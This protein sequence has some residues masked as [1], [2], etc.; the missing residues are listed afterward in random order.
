MTTVGATG[1]PTTDYVARFTA[2]LENI[3]K[4]ESTPELIRQQAISALDHALKQTLPHT[5]KQPI[6]N[7]R[8]SLT[9]I[10]K[11]SLAS[12]FKAIYAQMCVLAVSDLEAILK[13]YFENA[14]NAHKNLDLSN[15]G[16]TKL[17]VSLLDIIQNDL[18]FGGKV[19]K[20]I[21]EKQKLSFQDLK[22]I[23]D[24]FANYFGKEINLPKPVEQ[25]ICF[26]LEVRHVLVHKGG[27]VDK[28]FLD[29]TEV[30]KAN[31]KS[32]S[33]GQSV[34]LDQNDWSTIKSCFGSLVEAITKR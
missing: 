11:G 31:L 29:A 28:K 24:I 32:Y 6:E 34:E 7:A 2:S 26:Y 18:R 17:K 30:M 33:L 1:P 16:L 14:A 12:N 8:A 25:Q 10:S 15:I 3:D 4:L 9:N 21:L 13:Q 22:S 23:K 20:L 27:K 19:G 5:A